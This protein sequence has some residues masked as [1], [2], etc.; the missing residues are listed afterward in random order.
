VNLPQ[1]A[2]R[3]PLKR[4]IPA[5]GSAVENLLGIFIGERANHV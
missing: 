2:Q 5:A 3:H 1:L 4:R